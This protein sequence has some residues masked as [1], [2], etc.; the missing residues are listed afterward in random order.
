MNAYEL[1]RQL[2]IERRNTYG[3]V[4]IENYMAAHYMSDCE[5]YGF[6][7]GCDAECPVLARG[8]C[9]NELTHELG[10]EVPDE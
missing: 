2:R 4:S 8:E 10:V 5:R 3:T 9:E 1:K 7:Y 6:V